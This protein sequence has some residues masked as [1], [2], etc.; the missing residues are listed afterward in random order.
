MMQIFGNSIKF[1]YKFEY[2][3]KIKNKKLAFQNVKRG[4][5]PDLNIDCLYTILPFE[6]T[7]GCII[8]LC[9]SSIEANTKLE[10]QEKLG[11]FRYACGIHNVL[12]KLFPE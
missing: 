7:M 11:F 8:I 2:K 5:H 1:I 10:N 6:K 12:T 4:K 9:P 3:I